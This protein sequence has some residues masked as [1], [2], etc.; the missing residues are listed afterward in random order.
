MK[1]Y[2]PNPVD[3][4]SVDLPKGLEL[5]V[6]EMSKNV[7]EVWSAGRMK[8]G[9]TYEKSA[10]MPRRSILALCHMKN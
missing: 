9:W 5:L 7:H 4:K 3:T 10:T 6:E 1:K 2:I 8:D